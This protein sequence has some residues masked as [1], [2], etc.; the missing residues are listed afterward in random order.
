MK[1]NTDSTIVIIGLG[2]TGMLM[3]L[4][5]AR[6]KHPVEIYE[7]IGDFKTHASASR[8]ETSLDLSKRALSA[9]SELNLLDKVL[10]KSIETWN[11]VLTFQDKTQISIPHG[12]HPDDRIY[13]TSRSDLYSVLLAA[14]RKESSIKI[15]LSHKLISIDKSNR[16]L[17]FERT[18]SQHKVHKPY[19]RLLACDG[20]NSVVGTLLNDGDSRHISPAFLYKDLNRIPSAC[21][22]DFLHNSMY[23][24]VGDTFSILAHPDIKNGFSSTLVLPVVNVNKLNN[25]LFSQEDMS[26]HFNSMKS[27]K[28]RCQYTDSILLLGDAAH[29]MLPFLGQGTNCAFEDCQL[30]NESLQKHH[31][32]WEAAIPDFVNTR[33]ENTDAI[34]DMSE[35]EYQEF[36]P[37]YN[38]KKHQFFEQT[39]IQLSQ[40]YP[41]LFKPYRYLL[42]F[43]RIPYS[44]IKKQQH[45]QQQLLN[46]MYDR[47][48]TLTHI[49]WRMVSDWLERQLL[50][51]E[52]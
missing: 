42:A 13:N 52:F 32:C 28:I 9:L 7:R 27:L 14:V 8:R 31:Q 48:K 3:A 24:W 22:T 39:S 50:S 5:L 47:F 34:I 30:L 43:T 16:M 33:R 49:Q 10:A 18:K 15:F 37:N 19:A 44:E 25:L 11:R 21:K 26:Q 6:Q 35:S 46:K 45:V 51:C 2:L 38:M 17:H 12:Q 41:D 40:R 29:C 20:V 23:K 1:H 36:H 4:Y